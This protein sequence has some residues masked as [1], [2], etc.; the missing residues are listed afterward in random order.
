[1]EYLLPTSPTGVLGFLTLLSAIGLVVGVTLIRFHG[2]GHL[3]VGCSTVG[4]TIIGSGFAALLTSDIE[5]KE[6]LEVKA[7]LMPVHE[8]TFDKTCTQA[9]GVIESERTEKNCYDHDIYRVW[10]VGNRYYIGTINGDLA[11]I[12]VIFDRDGMIADYTDSVVF[13]SPDIDLRRIE[14][15]FSRS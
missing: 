12:G 2:I 8:R 1:M 9:G 15:S 3:I 6:F 7:A 11:N 5:H 14:Y 4:L 10:T 13:V